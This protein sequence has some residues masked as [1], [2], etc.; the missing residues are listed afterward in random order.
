ME[1]RPHRTQ[2][3]FGNFLHAA[4][5]F[6]FGQTEEGP[7]EILLRVTHWV[8]WFQPKS[9]PSPQA[10]R[11][12]MT[13]ANGSLLSNLMMSPM[14]RVP[15]RVSANTVKGLKSTH[16]PHTLSA[17]LITRA[18]SEDSAHLNLSPACYLHHALFT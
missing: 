13:C 3:N 18:S 1:C 4:R 15:Q 5:C 2:R 8:P 7:G 10:E 12:R 14:F 16:R 6:C 9:G 11:T 17:C